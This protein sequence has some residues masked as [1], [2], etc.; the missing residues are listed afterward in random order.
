M[1]LPTRRTFEQQ[2]LGS[3]LTYGL[4][5][6]LFHRDLLADSIKPV[7]HKWMV[8]MHDLSQSLKDHKLKVFD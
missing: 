3:L 7:I 6:T 4:I 1:S 8:E 5:E 2:F